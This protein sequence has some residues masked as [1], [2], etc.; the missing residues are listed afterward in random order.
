[1]KAVSFDL[2]SLRVI[3]GA[4]KDLNTELER[5]WHGSLTR[6]AVYLHLCVYVWSMERLDEED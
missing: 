5:I 4:S 2:G 1:L 6:K 3:A